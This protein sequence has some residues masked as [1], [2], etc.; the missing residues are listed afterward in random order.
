MLGP[1]PEA[2]GAAVRRLVETARS[3]HAGPDGE[4]LGYLLHGGPAGCDFLDAEG[5]VWWWC[6]WD[7]KVEHVPDGPRKVGTVA[8]A[9]ERVPELVAWLPHRP[10][11]AFNCP[12]C[13]QSGWLQ[14]PLP[15][16][17]CPDCSGMGW[18]AE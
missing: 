7:D 13:K 1:M 11:S 5:E 10:G 4:F 9:A 3:Q 12:V 18:V 15:R 2:V 6:A 8:I 14:P 16:I 17:Q